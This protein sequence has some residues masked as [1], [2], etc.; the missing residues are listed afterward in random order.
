M[1]FQVQYIWKPLEN[2]SYSFNLETLVFTIKTNFN[3]N[4]SIHDHHYFIN[5]GVSTIL[6]VKSKNIKRIKRRVNIT[7]RVIKRISNKRQFD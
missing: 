5:C 1:F 7:L 3:E 4:S 6:C 2:G